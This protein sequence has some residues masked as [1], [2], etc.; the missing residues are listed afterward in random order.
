MG[1]TDNPEGV[2]IMICLFVEHF[3]TLCDFICA[4]TCC[5]LFVGLR[6][7]KVAQIPAV[8]FSCKDR[9]RASQLGEV[10]GTSAVGL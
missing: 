9:E 6:Q 7:P 8:Y 4:K 10:S 5:G 2:N 3:T 1:N